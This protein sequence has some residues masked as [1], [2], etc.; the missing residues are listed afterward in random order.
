MKEYDRHLTS[1]EKDQLLL[2]W[3]DYQSE[4]REGKQD[5]DRLMEITN[6][7]MVVLQEDFCRD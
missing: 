3:V 2:D 4:A 7:F 1:E 6:R 5:H